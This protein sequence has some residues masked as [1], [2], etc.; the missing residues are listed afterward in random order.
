M[1]DNLLGKNDIEKITQRNLIQSS[2]NL[3]QK[4]I[5]F[6]DFIRW[7][8]EMMGKVKYVIENFCKSVFSETFIEKK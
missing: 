1:D 6:A 3:I 2:C 7:H 8:F 5:S 4:L